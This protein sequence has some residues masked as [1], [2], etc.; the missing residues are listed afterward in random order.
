MLTREGNLV[1]LTEQEV[2]A[3]EAMEMHKVSAGGYNI[4]RF[5]FMGISEF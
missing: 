4:I 5:S 1:S 3:Y 2:C